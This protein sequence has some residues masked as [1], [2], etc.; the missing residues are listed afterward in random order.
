MISLKNKRFVIIFIVIFFVSW[1]LGVFRFHYQ[2]AYILNSVLLFPCGFLDITLDDYA[3]HHITGRSIFKDEIFEIFAFL[4]S[5]L[6]QTFIYHW[7]Y[8]KVLNWRKNKVFK[9]N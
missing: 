8:K 5:V 1:I 6:G 9:G 3:W 4:L 7:I 2:W